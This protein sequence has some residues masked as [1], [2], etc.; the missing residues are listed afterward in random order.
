MNTSLNTRW[1]ISDDVVWAGHESVRLYYVSAG[2]FQTL[3]G[4]GSAIWNLVASGMSTQE[5]VDKLAGEYSSGDPQERRI[6]E[7]DVGAFLHEMSARDALVPAAAYAASDR[8][9]P[10]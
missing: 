9:G 3:N 1:T 10:A 7:T 8:G 6:I 2:E 5:I 4:T